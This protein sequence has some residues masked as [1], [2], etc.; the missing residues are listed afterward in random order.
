MKRRAQT[1]PTASSD[2]IRRRMIHLYNGQIYID[3]RQRNRPPLSSVVSQEYNHLRETREVHWWPHQIPK[4]A[5]LHPLDRVSIP[6]RTIWH[7]I[8]RSVNDWLR[9]DKCRASI[10][11]W[12]CD[13]IWRHKSGSTLGDGVLMAPHHYLN[14]SELIIKRYTPC[15]WE[16]FTSN[17]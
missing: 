15:P 16:Q 10:P 6:T 1:S 13:D 4:T 3:P 9:L 11:L 5:E 2:D 8:E 12:P 17:S 7:D 14:Q